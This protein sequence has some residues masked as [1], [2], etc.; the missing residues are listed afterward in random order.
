MSSFSFRFD[1]EKPPAF[2]DLRQS[3]TRAQVESNA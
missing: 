3:L 2:G 1:V